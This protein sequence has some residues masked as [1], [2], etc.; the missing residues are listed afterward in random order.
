MK[1]L[2]VSFS[3]G[4]TSAFMCRWLLENYSNEYQ[5]IFI[6]AN[7]GRE[8]EETLI[9]ADK[10]DKYFGLNLIWVEAIINPNHGIGPRAKVVTFETASRNGEPFEA[11]IAKEG[12]PNTSRA[13]CTDRLKTQVIRSW[14]REN[15]YRRAP[16]AI[17]MRADEPTRCNPD[18]PVVSRYNLVYPLAHWGSFDKQDVNDFWE[19]M[20][21]TL[22]IPEHYGNCKTCFKK[23]DNKLFLIASEQPDWF[24]WNIDMEKYEHVKAGEGDRHVW[25]RKKRDTRALLEQGG[26]MNAEHLEHLARNDPDAAGGCGESCNAFQFVGED[27]DHDWLTLYRNESTLPVTASWQGDP[28]VL[29][30]PTI[31]AGG[32]RIWNLSDDLRLLATL[33]PL[34]MDVTYSP[35]TDTVE[36]DND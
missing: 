21:F 25:W 10:C 19:D 20:S 1:P 22:E 13:H 4:K 24:T 16:T 5:F 32:V 15:G 17:G 12:I 18:A 28:S 9:F 3:G 2:I 34:V 29:G 7:T 23:S 8:H 26:L 11:F 14:M 31:V 30:E 36:T 33:D 35:N 6:F 27:D